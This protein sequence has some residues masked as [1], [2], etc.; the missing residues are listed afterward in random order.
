MSGK[1]KNVF[2]SWS[3][4]ASGHVA[5]RLHYVLP[6][7]VPS[8]E[9][10][11]SEEDIGK[12]TISMEVLF[13]SMID[14]KTAIICVT[15]SN[16][17]NRWMHFESGAVAAKLEDK[18]RLCTLLLGGLKVGDLVKSPLGAFQHTLPIKP[19]VLSMFKAIATV[20]SDLNEQARVEAS[21]EKWWSDIDEAL[22]SMP[23]EPAPAV[24]DQA[25]MIEQILELTMAEAQR[26]KEKSFID[27]LEPLIRTLVPFKDLLSR[28]LL[29]EMHKLH[30]EA[31][32]VPAMTTFAARLHAAID[33]S[34]VSSEPSEDLPNTAPP[35]TPPR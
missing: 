19:Q 30:R 13:R 14:A 35:S 27:D 10:F 21:F 20:T 29:D 3:G 9:P 22:T 26:R 1:T 23:T 32:P 31:A 17:E 34:R 33:A 12:G 16:L 11:F 6:M 7:V 5:K 8:A 24:R 28:K 18:A 2:I 25:E 4:T 15:P